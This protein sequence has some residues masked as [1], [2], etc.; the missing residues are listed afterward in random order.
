MSKRVAVITGAADGIGWATAQCFVQAGYHVVIAD[1][2]EGMARQRCKTLG[3]GHWVL[4]C[5][6]TNEEQVEDCITQVERHYGRIDVL[7]NNAGISEQN[8]STVEQD[9]A[10]F[11][12]LL[13]IHLGGTFLMSRAV[14]KVMLRQGHGAMVNISSIAAVLGLPKRNAYGAAKAGISSMTRSMSCEWAQQGIRVNA[15]APGYV[16]TE[17]VNAMEK[18]GLVDTQKIEQDTPMGRLGKPEEIARVIL[19]LAS[20]DA[21]YITGTTLMVDGGWSSS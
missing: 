21:S 3:D 20:D 4:V 12:Q 14:A 5:D 2:R 15:V 19:F 8:A 9:Y 1:I 13:D 16:R 10:K 11:R 6:V 18:D 7:V 17:L